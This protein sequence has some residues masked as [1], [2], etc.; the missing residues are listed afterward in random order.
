MRKLDVLKRPVNV[1]F[2]YSNKAIARGY[3]KYFENEVVIEGEEEKPAL[4]EPGSGRRK[5]VAKLVVYGTTSNYRAKTWLALSN[6]SG[7]KGPIRPRSLR[8]E[9]FKPLK[10][11]YP[12]DVMVCEYIDHLPP[13]SMKWEITTLELLRTCNEIGLLNGF[14]V[15][16]E[17]KEV[18]RPP[19]GIVVVIDPRDENPTVLRALMR[20]GAR[21]IITKPLTEEEF[22]R[23]VLEVYDDIHCGTIARINDDY[24]FEYE[25]E[26][27]T[28]ESLTMIGGTLLKDNDNL[29]IDGDFQEAGFKATRSQI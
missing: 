3:A 6:L 2:C 20:E 8:D 16:R 18:F 7:V 1:L 25:H 21:G 24:K 9:K 15:E 12:F 28:R 5:R 13:A 11:P 29:Q 27:G 23:T 4:Q 26:D 19:L 10:T 14:Y 22:K 17:G